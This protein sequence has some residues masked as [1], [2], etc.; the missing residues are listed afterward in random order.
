MNK[1]VLILPALLAAMGKS[2][3]LVSLGP[4]SH[5]GRT[6]HIP[7]NTNHHMRTRPHAPNDGRWHMKFHRARG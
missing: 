5:A 1:M 4:P 3:H 2:L 6:P 7:H